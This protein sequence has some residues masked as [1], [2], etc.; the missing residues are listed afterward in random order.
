MLITA[1]EKRKGTQCAVYIEGEYAMMLDAELI[2]NRGLRAGLEVDR[3]DI[4]EFKR[5]CDL[6]RTRERAL[7]LL[8]YKS[9]TK[10]ELFLKLAKTSDEE[11]A[12]EVTARMEELGLL[13]DEEY[14][15]RFANQLVN[16]KSY[17]INRVRQELTKKG[18]DRDIIDNTLAE[19]S[20]V[21]D[22]DE[23]LKSIIDKKYA[24]YLDDKKG[25]DKTI[26]ALLRLGY[27]FDD[28]RRVLRYYADNFEVNDE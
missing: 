3:D 15:Q 14:A 21:T 13:N 2:Y 17:G 18:I 19:L 7:Y 22:T 23:K 9:H 10:K 11:L 16:S 24:R 25:I 4:Y 20:Q 27:R 6:R 28:I 1:I 12:G 5:Q 8:G 26:N